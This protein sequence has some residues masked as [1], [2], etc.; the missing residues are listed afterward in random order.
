[1]KPTDFRETTTQA[2]ITGSLRIGVG[3]PRIHGQSHPDFKISVDGDQCRIDDKPV[4]SIDEWLR[5]LETD[6][7]SEVIGAFALAWKR[8]DGSMLL[9]RDAIGERTLYYSR[10]P[11]GVAFASSVRDLLKL[12]DISRRLDPLA[13]AMYLT[14]AYIPGHRTLIDGVYELLPGE[15]KVFRA[16]RE[17]SSQLWSIPP[18]PE[19]YLE[20]EASLTQRLR[21]ALESAVRDR[22]VPHKP[23][24]AFLSGGLDSSLVVALAN[25]L[26]DAVIHTFSASFGRDY[27]NELAFSTLLAKHCG[28]IHHIVELP[29][30]VVLHYLDETIGFLSDPIGDPLTVPNALLFREASQFSQCVLNGE[31]GDPCF[32]GPKNLPMV[33][34]E[35][36]GTSSPSERESSYLRAHLK[37]YDELAEMLTPEFSTFLAAH[38]LESEIQ[39]YFDDPRWRKFVTKLQMLNVRFKGGHHILPKVDALSAPFGMFPRS[40]LFDRR[41]VELSF[42]IPPQWK[43]YGSVEKYLLKQSVKDIVP[44]AIIRRP[45]SGMMVPVEG[46][47][48]GPLLPEAKSRLLDGLKNYGIFRRDYL[49]RLLAGKLGG[50]RPRHGVKIWL[51]ITLEAWLR[52]VFRG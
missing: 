19:Q 25:Q 41:V 22:L 42:E 21:L 44:D 6:R 31:G 38:Q 11:T 23:I 39:P 4:A 30:K 13:V 17:H 26:H 10:T 46:W 35:L 40:P 49:E 34:A 16:G 20:P 50:P 51:L 8:P 18:E 12:S 36:Y 28:T 24:A 27:P 43:L 52:K 29:S 47:F 14:Y 32:G 5:I 2:A 45:K 15:M 3:R 1:M 7:L 48:A 33:L 37:C 9:A